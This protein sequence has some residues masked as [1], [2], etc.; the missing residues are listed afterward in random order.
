[1]RAHH[2]WTIWAAAIASMAAPLRADTVAFQIRVDTTPLQAL[3]SGFIDLQLNPG[4]TDALAVKQ[5]FTSFQ[6]DGIA[7][8]ATLT[9]AA[10]GSL[11]DPGGGMLQNSTSFNDIFQEM[12]WGTF[13]SFYTC[14]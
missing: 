12:V 3:G 8:P 1:M 9:G 5:L 4:A 13:F 2:T 14:L 7:G 11:T 6:S 10:S